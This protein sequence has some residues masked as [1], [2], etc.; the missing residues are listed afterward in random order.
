MFICL[1][2]YLFVI[3]LN[4]VAA[5]V[6]APSL[7][8]CLDQCRDCHPYRPGSEPFNFNFEDVADEVG[9]ILGRFLEVPGQIR[10]ASM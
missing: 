2:V 7:L 5:T 10:G 1:F 4:T 6:Q 9:E 3:R 8:G